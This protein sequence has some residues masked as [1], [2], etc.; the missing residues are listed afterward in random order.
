MPE[1]IAPD[2]TLP[3]VVEREHFFSELC[4]GCRKGRAE[5]YIDQKEITEILGGGH[6]ADRR[7]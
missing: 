7:I 2:A 5:G 3:L 6:N 1:Y 4:V